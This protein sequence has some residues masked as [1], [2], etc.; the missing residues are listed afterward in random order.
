MKQILSEITEFRA[1]LTA[2][3][4]RHGRQLPWRAT[5]DPYAILVS[6]LMLQQTRAATVISYYQR[7]LERFPTLHDLANARESE[8]LHAWQGLGYYT[9]ARNLHKCAKII[10]TD[11][12]ERFP[13]AV[14]QLLRLPGIG[15]YTAGAIASFAFDLPAPIVDAN[16]ERALSRLLNLQEPVDQP[17]G[18]RIIWDLA[19]RYV[20]GPS[21]RVL[22]SALMELGATLC[23]PRKPLCILCPV[24]SFCAAGDP[25]SLPRKRERPKIEKK[26]EFHFLALKE[27]QVLLEQNLGRRWHGLW[28]LP[29][30]ASNSESNQ[31]VEVN[32]PFLSL[33]YPITRFVVRLNIFLSDPPAALSAGQ[34][35][36]GLESLESVPMPSPHRRAIEMALTKRGEQAERAKASAGLP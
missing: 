3:F 1:Q 24:R 6:E 30:L 18:G 28:I 26:D 8:V 31:G 36:Y 14:D 5:S 29:V 32:L 22:N 16:V 7:W 34:A 35:W 21:P 4:E 11:W 25:E 33:S 12:N 10:V 23:L 27:G 9:R 2:W 13:S 17:R 19:S 15:R 20:Q